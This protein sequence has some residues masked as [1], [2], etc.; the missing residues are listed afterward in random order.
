MVIYQSEKLVYNTD[1]N[2]KEERQPTEW[3]K[4]AE[5]VCQTL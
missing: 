3:R 2:T 1:M 4:D 5:T